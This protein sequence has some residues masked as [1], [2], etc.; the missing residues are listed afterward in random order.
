MFVLNWSDLSV[1]S[2]PVGDVQSSLQWW[3]ELSLL[4][5]RLNAYL[6]ADH[7]SSAFI[8]SIPTNISALNWYWQWQLNKSNNRNTHTRRSSQRASGRIGYW[9]EIWMHPRVITTHLLQ[10]HWIM[11]CGLR[12][13]PLDAHAFNS[14]SYCWLCLWEHNT[15][16]YSNQLGHT[17]S[18]DM[19]WNGFDW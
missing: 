3:N 6:S 8:I 17:S 15:T 10:I 1:F 9:S 4:E 18:Y 13:W 16:Y 7:T 2:L 12:I 14:V 11:C 5:L 19:S